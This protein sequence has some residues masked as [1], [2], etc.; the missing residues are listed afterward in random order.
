MTGTHSTYMAR[1]TA[2]PGPGARPG[3]RQC[4]SALNNSTPSADP[5]V[6]RC[7][8][9][10]C[11]HLRSQRRAG[12][13]P[14]APARL[15]RVSIPKNRRPKS[16]C[17]CAVSLARAIFRRKMGRA[18]GI[19]VIISVLAGTRPP[20]RVPPTPLSWLAVVTAVERRPVPRLAHRSHLRHSHAALYFGLGHESQYVFNPETM[21]SIGQQA[22]TSGGGNMTAVAH[23]V[24]ALLRQHYPRCVHGSFVDAQAVVYACAEQQRARKGERTEGATS[25]E[26]VQAIEAPGHPARG[27]LPQTHTARACAATR[28]KP[29]CAA[30]PGRS[31]RLE[32][33]V[34]SPASCRQIYC[35]TPA[36]VVQQC[37][38]RHG[39]DV[40][41]A[42]QLH[43]CVCLRHLVV[44]AI[45]TACNSC[46]LTHLT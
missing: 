27:A 20:P 7:I 9:H 17:E 3:Q 40:C 33:G 18:R 42:L 30:G 8:I 21:K 6:H 37:W 43:R 41:A 22:V 2:P 38:G 44:P 5:T 36:V 11:A 46:L 24:E 35:S 31:V 29:A 15:R 14:G 19:G 4:V 10:A 32:V 12:P 16:G 23:H 1:I 34:R 25:G 13:A 28:R 39:R 45:T 26:H